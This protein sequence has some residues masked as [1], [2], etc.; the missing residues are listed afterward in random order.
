MYR[1]YYAPGAA[2]LAVHWLLIELGVGFELSPVDLT[3]ARDS[4][5]LALN[6]TG[7]VPTL[8][9]DGRAV[10]ESAAILMLLAER[11]P[12]AGLAPAPGEAERAEYLQWMVYLANA[13]M[14]AFRRWF[15]AEVTAAP[16]DVEAF[17]A[18][19][20]AG[21]EAVWR[22]V[23]ERFA[24]GRPYLLGERLSVADFLLTMLTRWSRNME[25]PATSWPHLGVYIAR[26]KQ[27][28]GLIEV[29]QREGLSDWISA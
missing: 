11:H 10:T 12:T 15:Y 19:A 2:S 25:M 26:M 29:H 20:R 6:P 3:T 8:I 5:Y 4:A 16:D 9:V 14:P 27:R 24:D 21:I 28:P 7:Q 18:D 22:R 13:L 23:D 1:L 17:K